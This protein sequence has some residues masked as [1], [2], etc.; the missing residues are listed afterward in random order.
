MNNYYY[1]TMKNVKNQ[2]EN[3]IHIISNTKF[4]LFAY[5]KIYLLKLKLI[6][7]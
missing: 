5:N 4:F 1:E 2:G 6:T 3:Q 7:I